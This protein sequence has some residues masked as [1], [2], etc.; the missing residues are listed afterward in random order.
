LNVRRKPNAANLYDP[1]LRMDIHVARHPGRCAGRVRPEHEAD[2]IEIG[3]L[4]TQMRRECCLIRPRAMGQIVPNVQRLI[5]AVPGSIE[6]LGVDCWVEGL[7]SNMRADQ[8][9][10]RRHEAARRVCNG[11]GRQSTGERL[12]ETVLVIHLSWHGRP[13]QR[14]SSARPA[15]NKRITDHK[16]RS[17]IP[18]LEIVS[19]NMSAA[20]RAGRGT[21]A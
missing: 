4:I 5:R 21:A 7:Q 2:L 14:F 17:P 18:L 1:V 19:V 16:E 12:F 11:A 9:A 13:S 10:P 3:S 15:D 6:F 20:R 8:R